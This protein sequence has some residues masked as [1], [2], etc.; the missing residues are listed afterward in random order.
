[1]TSTGCCTLLPA[2]AC[3]KNRTTQMCLQLDGC[4]CRSSC[5]SLSGHKTLTTSSILSDGVTPPPTSCF[6]FCKGRLKCLLPKTT[7]MTAVPL[8]LNTSCGSHAYSTCIFALH[9]MLCCYSC[10][11]CS[12]TTWLHDAPVCHAGYCHLL[13]NGIDCR[14]GTKRSS[15]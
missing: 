5:C 9:F 8:P 1:M 15:Q 12:C 6:R 3:N 11:T 7:S 14:L 4:F 2:I 13:D 10:F